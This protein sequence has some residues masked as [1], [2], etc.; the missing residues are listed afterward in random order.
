[1]ARTFYIEA[2]ILLAD[3]ST[4]LH[5]ETHETG[6]ECEGGFI[7]AYSD[8]FAYGRA[9]AV[10]EELGGEVEDVEFGYVEPSTS[11][12]HLDLY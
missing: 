3:G 7:V 10:A 5:S 6:V 1:M 9:E 12:D 4:I 2:A 11:F 8:S